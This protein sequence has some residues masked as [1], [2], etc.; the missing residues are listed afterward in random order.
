MRLVSLAL[1]LAFV[2]STN[3]ADRRHVL[4]GTLSTYSTPPRGAD[5]RVDCQKLLAQLVDLHANSYSFAVH[6]A[7]TDWD[8]LKIFLPLAR[9]KNIRVWVSLVPPSES[10]PHT[11]VYCEPYRLDYERW[12]VEFAKLSLQEPNL[13]G[14]SIDDFPYNLKFFTPERM[15]GILDGAHA[16]NPNFAFV[17]CVYG[18]QINAAFVKNY[19]PMC[20][21]ILFP[22]RDES[23]T[24]N[25]KD[26]THVAEEVA[27]IRQKIGKDVPIIVDIYYT[28][29]SRLGATTPEYCE[30]ATIDAH[31]SGAAVQI[32]THPDPEKTPE[33]YQIVKRLFTEWSSHDGPLVPPRRK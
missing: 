9:Q 23:H 5:H 6:Q 31:K 30:T 12:A 27:A 7:A 8:D 26:P 10:P 4:P 11:K 1:A 14:W 17:P 21:G 22:Y 32:Y 18:R 13:V 25:L 15:K 2:I 16:I 24:P 28:R 3:A 33:K 19:V 29:H 20:D